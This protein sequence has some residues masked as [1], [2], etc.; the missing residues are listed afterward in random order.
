VYSYQGRRWFLEEIRDF[1]RSSENALGLELASAKKSDFVE[2]Q[3]ALK[4]REYNPLI[5]FQNFA[6]RRACERGAAVMD[7]RYLGTKYRH[8]FHI[9]GK[10]KNLSYR[11]ANSPN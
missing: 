2:K 1:L 9:C 7:F 10:E 6:S 8:P 5:R 11:A 4:A 3:L